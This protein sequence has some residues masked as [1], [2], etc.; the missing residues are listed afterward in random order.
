MLNLQE[1]IDMTPQ[2]KCDLVRDNSAGLLPRLYRETQQLIFKQR[3]SEGDIKRLLEIIDDMA[4]EVAK[5]AVCRKGCSH[6]CYQAVLI[7]NW[8]A[9]RIARFTGREM[10]DYSGYDPKHDSKE[11]LRARFTNK[12]CT[13]LINGGCSIYPARPVACRLHYSMADEV[14]LCDIQNSPGASVPYFNF[15]NMKMA[16]TMLFFR[17]KPKFGDIRE[18]FGERKF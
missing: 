11:K 16:A 14:E 10:S 2:D 4:G 1:R 7:S 13:F 18:F 6:C 9:K 17:N 15:E 3:N 12:P 5:V 8:E